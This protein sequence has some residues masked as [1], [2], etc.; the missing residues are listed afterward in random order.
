[1]AS[2]D[3]YEILGVSQDA[4]EA[5][6]KRAYRAKARDLHPD[7]GGDEEEFKELTT[8]YEVLSNPDARANYDRYGD[9]RGP[10]GAG[11]GGGDPFSGFGDLSDLINAF[12]GGG[13]GMGGGQRTRGGA[14][15]G[16]DVLI[17]VG[18]SLEEAASGLQRDLDVTVPR[19]CDVCHGSGAAEGSGPVRCDTCGGAGAVQQVRN[20][21]FG[22]MMT[23]SVCPTCRGAGE[24]IDNPCGTCGGEGRR[25]LSETVT[26]EIPPGVDDG[27]RLR[28]SG[29][30]EAGRRGAPSGDLYVRIRVEPHPTFTRDGNDLHCELEVPMV[31][32]ALG[33]DL[34]LPTL[35]GEEEVLT[36]PSGTQSG[37]VLTLRRHGMPKLNGG[38]ARGNLRIHTRVEIPKKLDP[39]E[40]KLLR[41]LAEL[42]DEEPADLEG[43][44]SGWWARLRKA[45]GG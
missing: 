38:G 43:G 35:D 8:A 3:L 12:F 30:G 24:R 33:T 1:V 7:S 11:M 16:R 2:Q 18:I 17:D 32:A 39:E 6:I 44:D 27:T 15:E 5:D 31:Q 36:V 14:A 34:R 4:S 37:D 19:E 42:R 29:R 21:V 28:M 22:Q 45:F 9:P 10:Q 41:S 23:Q 40:E 25:Q 20:S 13:G 26:A